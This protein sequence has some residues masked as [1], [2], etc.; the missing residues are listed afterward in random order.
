MRQLA[1]RDWASASIVVRRPQSKERPAMFELKT[2]RPAYVPRTTSKAS[3]I[4]SGD[5][6]GA[7]INLSGRRRFTSQR[8]VLHAV[9]AA[10][11][12]VESLQIARDA[13][14]LFRDAHDV[15]VNGNSQLPGI[16]CDELERAYFGDAQAH[17]KIIEFTDLAQSAL[18]A[19][20]ANR[21]GTKELLDDLVHK[22]TSILA[23]LNSLT[24]L[25]EDLSKR[26]ATTVKKQLN[27]IMS[28]IESIAK[29]ARMV[30]FNAQI[31]AARAGIAGKE[32]SVVAGL[33]TSITG[34]I[35]D[36]VREALNGAAA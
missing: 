18:D 8:L 6:L 29:Q 23:V 21:R 26:H 17:G 5:I 22:A 2:N 12:R 19:I 3:P 10:Q 24:Q 31:I 35:D 9:L 7:L 15:L 11:G 36:L 4:I 30:S 25:Y 20:Q 14:K 34:E 16:F 1:P 13:L 27:S 28:D 32:F 33:L